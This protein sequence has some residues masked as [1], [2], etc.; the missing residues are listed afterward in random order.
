[1]D[2]VVL[3]RRLRFSGPP[4]EELLAELRARYPR[5]ALL[6]GFIVRWREPEP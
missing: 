1:V 4:P 6:G 3:N 5:A 2:V